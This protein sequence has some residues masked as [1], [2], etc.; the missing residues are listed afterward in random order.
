MECGE[1]MIWLIVL[2]VIRGVLGRLGGAAGWNTKFRDI[3]CPIT[4][5]IDWII[6]LGWYQ[7]FQ[8]VYLTIFVLQFSSFCT[9]WDWLFGEDNL[10]FSGLIAGLCIAPILFMDL[11]LWWLVLLRGAGLCVLWGSLNRW[12]PNIPK[13]DVVEEFTRYAVAI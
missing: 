4:I 7:S 5:V 3:G 6:I 12:L 1:K 10:W 8:W 2:A 11:S 13:R 9:Y